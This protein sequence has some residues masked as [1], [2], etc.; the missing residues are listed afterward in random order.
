M[1][2]QERGQPRVGRL[3]LRLLRGGGAGL[4]LLFRVGWWIG[5]GWIWVSVSWSEMEMDDVC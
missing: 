1:E 2:P 5:L 3:V 4:A